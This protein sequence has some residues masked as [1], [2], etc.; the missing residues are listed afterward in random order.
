MRT[1]WLSVP[2]AILLLLA[3]FCQAGEPSWTV[4]FDFNDGAD[5]QKVAGLDAGG[6]TRYTTEQF[7]EGGRA[8]SLEAK[9]GKENFGRWGGRM[10]F[11]SRLRRGDEVWWRVRTF[12]P[13]GMDYSANPRLKFLR[14]HTCTPEGKNRGYNDIY[15][16]KPG[17]K[18]PFQFIYEGAHKWSAVS[19]AG[20]AI[21]PD[22]WETYEYYLKLD[23]RNAEEGGQARIRFWKNGKLLRDITDRKTLKLESDYA[24]SALLFT[25]WNS[26]PYMGQ[27]VF[28]EGGP[29]QPKEPV[30]C[31]MHPG[32]TFRVEKT[33]PNVVYL[34]DPTRDWRKRA[35]PFIL[36]TG[37]VLTGQTS[38]NT[39]KISEVLHT[40]PLMDIKMYADD[41]VLTC[42]TPRGRD[43]HGNPCIGMEPKRLQAEG[44]PG[45]QGP[46][47]R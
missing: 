43:A 38:K 36:K 42:N 45:P 11:P 5:G 47:R 18:I 12:W 8:A 9:R 32:I 33:G 44:L 37:E 40:H 26:S 25:Y 24:D 27:I 14:V 16:N 46:G 10:H 22:T 1:I 34:I 41:M 28:E 35:R 7:F 31:S 2:S 30:T 6:W 39:C 29:F 19:D 13:K 3:P 21:V 4:K 17:S 15:I 23:S 20:D